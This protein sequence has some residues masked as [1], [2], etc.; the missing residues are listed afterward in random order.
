MG[1]DKAKLT[2]PFIVGII[3]NFFVLK[4]LDGAWPE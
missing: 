2:N 3:T 1:S 4:S